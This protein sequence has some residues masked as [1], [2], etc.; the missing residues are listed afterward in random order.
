M[1]DFVE[2]TPGAEWLRVDD[3]YK[4]FIENYYLMSDFDRK[5][6]DK[7]KNYSFEKWARYIA[8]KI[9]QQVPFYMEEVENIK[10]EVKWNTMG[11]YSLALRYW[12]G[13]KSKIYVRH[14]S[15]KCNFNKFWVNA[16]SFFRQGSR[17]PVCNESR[18]ETRIRYFLNYYKIT[19]KPQYCFDDLVGKKNKKLKF[20]FGILDKNK[21]LLMLVEFDGIYHYET[22]KRSNEDKLKSQQF[23]DK[24]KD[25]YCKKNNIKLLRIPYWEYKN[26]EKILKENIK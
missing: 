9:I 22:S 13:Y 14:N 21:N 6:F 26:I 11:E 1:I 20:D 12:G 15:S 10:N 8:R 7:R 4:G 2:A 25:D 3:Y 24:L 23:R 19:F 18:G 17:C 16:N 5:E